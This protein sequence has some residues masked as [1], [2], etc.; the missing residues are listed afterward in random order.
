MDEFRQKSID[1]RMQE[2]KRLAYK[3]P[4]RVPVV[5]KAGNKNT[6]NTEH[7]K[8]LVP[9]TQTIGDFIGVIRKKTS[10]KSY[11]ALFVFVN[12]VLPPMS[13][14]MLNVHTE[15]HEEDG[16]LYITYSLENTFG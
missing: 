12:G 16:F 10:I 6:P 14:T 11:Q 7:F 13:S 5:I 4:D 8:Y 1:Y 2:A 9:K 15:H 3:Y